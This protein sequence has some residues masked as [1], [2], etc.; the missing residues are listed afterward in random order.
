MATGIQS[1][2][3]EF[4]LSVW[5]SEPPAGAKLTQVTSG[6]RMNWSTLGRK[7]PLSIAAR[8]QVNNLNRLTAD[9]VSSM[10]CQYGSCPIRMGLVE[11]FLFL[12]PE[13][14]QTLSLQHT[15]PVLTS[16]NLL[17]TSNHRVPQHRH[18]NILGL[19]LQR[20]LP[21]SHHQAL[22]LML[23]LL[24]SHPL[25][26]LLLLQKVVTSGLNFIWNKLRHLIH[27]DL[28]ASISNN[29]C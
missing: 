13:L 25:L 9:S 3:F 18:T 29:C 17:F 21:S 7:T 12:Q 28:S 11:I 6:L 4:S 24:Q 19:Q 23:L 14:I 22:L 1:E 26:L 20:H 27:L 16:L 15:R 2:A 8:F 10:L 5:K